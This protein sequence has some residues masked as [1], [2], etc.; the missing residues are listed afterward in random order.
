[1][2]VSIESVLIAIGLLLLVSTISSTV[3]G[4]WGIPALVI[5]LAIG[6]IAGSE[7]FGGIPF[8]D[9]ERARSFGI[10][11]LAI[12]LFS[13]GLDTNWRQVRPIVGRG[14]LLATVGVGITA[15][16]VGLLAAP[17]L[18]ITPIEG[19]LLGAVVS[20]TDAAAVLSI[21]RTRNLSLRPGLQPLL[22]LESGCNDPM[23]VFLT[24]ALTDVIVRPETGPGELVVRFIMQMMIGAAAG[25]GFGRLGIAM[26]NRLRLQIE[27]LYPV[28]LLSIALLAYGVTERAYGNGF[29][30]VYIAGVV[31][32]NGR[33]V[34]RR[35]LMHFHDG[36]AWL[37]QIAMFLMLGL[38]VF[39]SH[40]PP[41]ATRGVIV[42]LV[43][44]VVAR[45]VS[46][47]V[48]LA[49]T[50]MRVRE[51]AFVS[52]VGLR[53]AVPIILA[54]FPL[55][56]GVPRADLLFDL[57][58]FTVVVSV[59]L[60]GTA[61]P[62]IARWLKVGDVGEPRVRSPIEVER[63][64]QSHAELHEV[65]VPFGSPAANRPIFALGLPAG[66]LI[67]LINRDD[68]FIMAGGATVLREGDVLMV[69]SENGRLDAFE[70]LLGPAGM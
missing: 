44:M 8:D 45:P 13:G 53:G 63:T 31:I 56:A 14:V 7:G 46:V 29:L 64:E 69:L 33:I 37:M 16:I 51:K 10:V 58:F 68:E 34:H 4:R 47:F 36:M 59:I 25:Y 38:L 41:V 54:T 20:S 30:A 19:L 12:I 62:S 48:A 57:V 26:V 55:L 5:F 61:I 3:A 50:P 67:V 23:A 40:L 11:A 18:G 6:M 52:L 66:A 1:M 28:L 24:A 65:I 22:E 39:P 43:L 60:Q 42:A 49:L 27:G 17:L 21:L 15:A 32:G 2:H 70:G 35:S 9:Y